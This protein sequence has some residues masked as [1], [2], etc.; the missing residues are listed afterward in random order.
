[1]N[2]LGLTS[3][4]QAAVIELPAAPRLEPMI[5]AQGG[6][7]DTVGGKQAA[8]SP[9]DAFYVVLDART[10]GVMQPAQRPLVATWAAGYGTAAGAPTRLPPYLAKALSSPAAASADAVFAL[11]LRDVASPA[12]V[13]YALGMGD[14]PSLEGL[15][16][17]VDQLLPAL[18]SLAGTTVTVRAG[19]TLDAEWSIDF[20]KD[21]TVL[22]ANANALVIDVLKSTGL[23]EPDAE[24]WAFKA[25]GKRVVGRRALDEESFGRLVALMAPPSPAVEAGTDAGDAQPAAERVKSAGPTAQ[26]SQA[27]YRAVAKA[28]DSLGPTPSATQSANTL[29]TQAR[30][31][32]QL[33]A[34]DVDPALLEWGS[35]VA[36]AFSR[37]GHE[38]AVGAQRAQAAAAGVASPTA[39]ANYSNNGSPTSTPESR[40]AFRNAQQ[41]RRQVSQNERA[42]ASDRALTILNPLPT[43]RGKIRGE[44]SQKYRVEF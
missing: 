10:L 3:T 7:L 37:A 23:Y 40:A 43:A 35:S 21:V 18:A 5:Q 42:A 13:A 15:E 9:R 30:R 25:D 29:S 22:G 41:Q 8:W 28:I 20:D 12:A 4:W 27:Y 2:P 16:T 14:L 17:G 36:D 38:V 24:K 39:S 33:P 26:A 1:M 44:M 32:E 34:L 6:Y 11:D 19:A 31:I